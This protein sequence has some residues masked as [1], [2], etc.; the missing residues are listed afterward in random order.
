[1]SVIEEKPRSLIM[2]ATPLQMLIAEKI[3]NLN[4]DKLFDLLLIA[5]S[6]SSKYRHY[7]E[8]LDY[9]CFDNLYYVAEPGLK[10]FLNYIKCLRKSRIN[11]K[12]QNIYLAN[13]EFR[14]FQYVLSKNEQSNIYT[15]DDGT[16]NIYLS[17]I[18]HSNSKPV[19]FKR[20]VWRVFGIKYYLEDIRNFS[21]L[22]YTI[23]KD[24]PNIINNI[25]YISLMSDSNQKKREINNKVIRFYLG[26]PLTDIS[27][28]FDLAYVSNNIDKL[29][30]DYYY[31][32]PRE[33]AYPKGDY[34][35]VESPLIF[36]DYIVQFLKDNTNVNIEVF[37]FTS[38]ALL[39]I[40]SLNRVKAIYIYESQIFNM[41]K[42]F[43]G[44]TEESFDIPFLD[45]DSIQ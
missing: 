10:G 36:E 17:S 41:L 39:N 22:H 14:H 23:Y 7:Y 12:Y 3:I 32:H 19:F 42:N 9:I 43:Y 35:I 30:I 34:Q 6:I 1:M 8:K 33:K 4:S 26:Q 15:F 13:I 31:P 21:K 40:M 44:F 28:D 20:A 11:K 24:I 2:C 27:K 16:V 25:R 5:P 38:T 45:L 37:S 18:Y 29:D